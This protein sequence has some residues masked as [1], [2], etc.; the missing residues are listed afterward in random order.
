ME[1]QFQKILTKILTR[2]K[3]IEEE[4]DAQ[5]G[6]EGAQKVLLPFTTILKPILEI[7]N[8]QIQ[9]PTRDQGTPSQLSQL[10]RGSQPGSAG[11]GKDDLAL[12]IEQE[13][14]MTKGSRQ[15]KTRLSSIDSV[16]SD[17]KAKK[18]NK[19]AKREGSNTTFT[20]RRI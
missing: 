15:R 4:A 10:R 9:S 14:S 20:A 19:P 1:D 3:Q 2:M 11:L 5:I 6:R 18:F 8:I 13:R 7:L 12:T 16:P 17:K